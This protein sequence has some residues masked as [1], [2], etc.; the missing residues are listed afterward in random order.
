MTVKYGGMPSP[1]GLRSVRASYFGSAEFKTLAPEEE[2]LTFSK[3]SHPSH[4]D[5][6]DVR[7]MTALYGK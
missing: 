7:R 1:T 6:L 2:D 5:V 3:R 4:L